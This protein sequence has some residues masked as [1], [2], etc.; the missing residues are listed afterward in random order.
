MHHVWT[1]GVR[2]RMLLLSES[3][4]SSPALNSRGGFACERLCG[5]QTPAQYQPVLPDGQRRQY[6]SGHG[7]RT[8]SP[9][10]LSLIQWTCRTVHPGFGYENILHAAADAML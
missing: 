10:S 4:T 8:Q 3:F 9:H 6:C 1:T 2:W 5:P 7:R